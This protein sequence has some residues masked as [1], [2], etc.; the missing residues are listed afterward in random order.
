MST[1]THHVDLL[2]AL[3]KERLLAASANTANSCCMDN[4]NQSMQKEDQECH[5]EFKRL[6]LGS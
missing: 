1:T 6:F 5:R 2:Q 4:K 3:H